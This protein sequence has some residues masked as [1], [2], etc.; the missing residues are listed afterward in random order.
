MFSPYSHSVEFV[1]ELPQVKNDPSFLYETSQNYTVTHREQQK[2]KLNLKDPGYTSAITS[3]KTSILSGT[4][5]GKTCPIHGLNHSLNDCRTFR[6]KPLAERKQ[7]LKENRLC[8]KCCGTVKHM[9][10]DCRVKM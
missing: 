6:P 3:N 4:E 10:I 9:S 2:G 7:F 1:Y 8:D 5:D